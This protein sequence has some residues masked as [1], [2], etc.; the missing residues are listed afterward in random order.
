[1]P[2]MSPRERQ[3]TDALNEANETIRQLRELLTPVVPF[4]SY[5][6]MRVTRTERLVLDCLMT[7]NARGRDLLNARIAHLNK[8]R[9]PVGDKN[10]D[11]LIC[12][13]RKVLPPNVTIETVRGEGFCM[14]PA[15]IANLR[16]LE[17][18]GVWI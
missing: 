1:M 9:S 7:G 4:T 16:A 15:S 2:Q 12:R 17:F 3:L 13:L 8:H 5:R 6:G 11:V 14:S 10:I 18:P